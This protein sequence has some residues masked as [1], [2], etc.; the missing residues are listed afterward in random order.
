MKKKMI[1]FN[2]LFLLIILPVGCRA[3]NLSKITKMKKILRFLVIFFTS[4]GILPDIKQVI[5]K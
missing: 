3:P 5:I 2:L 1:L 4:T